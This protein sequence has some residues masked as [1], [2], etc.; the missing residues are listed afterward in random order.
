MNHSLYQIGIGKRFRSASICFSRPRWS[1]HSA[2][3]PCSWP[4]PAGRPEREVSARIRP[5]TLRQKSTVVWRSISRAG[6]RTSVSSVAKVRPPATAVASC[7]HQSVEGPPA[8]IC[9]VKR[10]MLSF[11]HHRHQAEDRRHRGQQHRPEALGAG[12]Q[13]GLAMARPPFA[14]LVVGVDQHDVVVHDD[15]G[16]RDDADAGHDDAE[17]LVGDAADRAARPRS[18]RRSP[19]GSG[20]PGRS[21]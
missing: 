16:E 14:Q 20:P 10:S 15:A 3:A 21:C 7:A 18:R 17:R 19:R 1:G 8:V 13:D 11:K 2:G 12:P 9:R 6:V 5:A 4:P